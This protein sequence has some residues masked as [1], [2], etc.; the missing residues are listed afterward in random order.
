MRKHEY[1]KCVCVCFI[2]Y[3]PQHT[4]QGAM[5]DVRDDCAVDKNLKWQDFLRR[6]REVALLD[7]IDEENYVQQEVSASRPF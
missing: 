4:P 1:G 5:D 3:Y 2:R 6:Q 7:E